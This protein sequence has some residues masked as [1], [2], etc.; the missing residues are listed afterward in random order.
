MNDIIAEPKTA[1]PTDIETSVIERYA[2][3]AEEIEPALC[4][5]TNSYDPRWL[6]MIP[7]EI[8]AKDYGCGDPTRYVG[9]GETVVD[10]G[11]GG[12][13]ICYILAQK[14]GPAGRVIGVD[15]NDAMLQLARKY[16][17]EMTMKL[18]YDNVRFVKAKIQ[19]MELDLDAVQ[20][21][22]EAYPI[23]SVGDLAEFNAFCSQMRSNSPAVAP[24]SVDVVVSNCVLNLVRSEEKRQLFAEIF[25]VLKRGGRAVISDIVC[26]ETP[27]EVIKNDPNLWSGCIAG[28]FTETGLLEMFQDA[29]FHGVEIL[30]RQQE[31][32][33][34]I[35]GVEFRSMTVRAF[36]GK[37]GPCLERNQAVIYRG[38]WSSVRD[39][40]GHLLNRGERM[41][42]CDKTFKL[43]TDPNGPYQGEII[44]IHPHQEIPL[45]EA[46]PFNCRAS[47]LRDPRATKG[48]DYHETIASQNPES[49]GPEGCC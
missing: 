48:E 27:T 10:L 39:D 37:Q 29:G 21:Q 1:L 11:S 12:G 15:F 32:W 36:K 22:L 19:D 35:D 46:T 18:G 43:L 9:E 6:A 40:D 13:K 23:R 14:V 7:E 42:V 17:T 4:C 24:N 30:E 45:E 41:A 2:A 8:L 3:A 47:Q 5:P 44:P 16:E 49:C 28:A 33:Q 34:T 31:P 38:P 26:D 20:S 25:R